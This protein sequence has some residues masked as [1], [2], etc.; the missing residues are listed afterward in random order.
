M[1]GL[2]RYPFGSLDVRM[3]SAGSY[4]ERVAATVAETIDRHGV[5]L[6]W[7]SDQTGIPRTTL[8]RRLSGKSPFTVAELDA[9]AAALR[10]PVES[11]TLAGAAA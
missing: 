7:L 4:Q 1:W 3:E 5:K 6:V 8:D 11:L 10:I 2:T 9:I